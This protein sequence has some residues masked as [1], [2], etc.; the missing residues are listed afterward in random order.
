MCIRDSFN[1]CRLSKVKGDAYV[2]G[3]GMAG[4][5]A[6]TAYAAVCMFGSRA[7]SPEFTCY[8][9][10][11]VACMQVLCAPDASNEFASQRSKRA[12][13][14]SNIAAA[15]NRGN[16]GNRGATLSGKNAIPS[17]R[18]GRKGRKA[19]VAVADNR[20]GSARKSASTVQ[21]SAQRQRK[22]ANNAAGTRANT[23]RKRTNAFRAA[24]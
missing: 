14:R 4:A 3:M 13:R 18:S 5:G 21:Q 16:S 6:V 15:G 24:R 17:T 7:V 23:G 2:R 20:Q 8:F 11:M 19:S 10:V 9:W 12:A 22:F 1:G